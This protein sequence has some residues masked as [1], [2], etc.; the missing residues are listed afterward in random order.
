M[1]QL[2]KAIAI[3]AA[4]ILCLLPPAVAAQP[5]CDEIVQGGNYF[6][7][8]AFEDLS[9]AQIDALLEI[10]SKCNP[11]TSTIEN[12]DVILEVRV[13]RLQDARVQASMVEARQ[14]K[15]NGSKQE[16]VKLIERARA[17]PTDASSKAALSQIKTDMIRIRNESS[18]VWESKEWN[19]L[20]NITDE[21]LE[22]IETGQMQQTPPKADSGT[23]NSTQPGVSS[24]NPPNL[25]NFADQSSSEARISEMTCS[26]KGTAVLGVVNMGSDDP[27]EVV[28][29][30]LTSAGDFVIEGKKIAAVDVARNGGSVTFAMISVED[31]L[32]AGSKDATGAPMGLSDDENMQFHAMQKIFIEGSL[33][34]R[35]RFAIYD[36]ANSRLTFADADGQQFKN[37]SEASCM[38]R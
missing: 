32:L 21:K 19:E 9:V 36:V 14:A 35:K 26:A 5:T 10:A 8:K 20:Y 17:L 33:N 27:E 30:A 4:T 38:A 28:E 12:Y 24:S 6:Q 18:E 1:R 3:A 31:Y 29:V 2:L 13:S 25:Q 22:A 37:V 11:D 16:L 23:S 7:G 34:G 15:A